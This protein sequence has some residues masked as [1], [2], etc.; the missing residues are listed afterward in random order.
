VTDGAAEGVV[1]L[2]D[3]VPPLLTA[4]VGLA[5]GEVPAPPVAVP[6]AGAV[7]AGPGLTDDAGVGLAGAAPPLTPPPRVVPWPGFP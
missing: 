5:A 1:L 3:L 2:A 7:V 6:L 4:G